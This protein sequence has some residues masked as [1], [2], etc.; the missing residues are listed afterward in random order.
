GQFLAPW[1]V[2]NAIEKVESAGNRQILVTERGTSFGYG[3]LVVDMRGLELMKDFGYPVVMD[4]THAVQLPG[5]LG[6][7]TAGERRFAPTLMRAAAAVGVAGIFLETHP[8]PDRALSDGPN[9]VKL[10]DV[11]DL[12]RLVSEID[13][14]V[15]RSGGRDAIGVAARAQGRTSRAGRDAIGV[16]A[17]AQGRT[18]RAGRDA[19]GGAARAAPRRPARPRR[20]ALS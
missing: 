11:P 4:A 5:G 13:A 2:R 7:A 3:N 8:E 18:S 6:H 16:A 1:D 20:P 15:K 19:I 17:R 12:V 14:L 9:S 10:S